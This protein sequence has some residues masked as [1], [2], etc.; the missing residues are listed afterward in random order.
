M[1]NPF[2]KNDCNHLVPCYLDAEKKRIG[3]Y[4]CTMF[5]SHFDRPY[6]DKIRRVKR[7]PELE[8]DDGLILKCPQCMRAEERIGDNR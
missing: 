3:K 6:G 1:K 7:Y 8:H 4:V 2:C 5:I